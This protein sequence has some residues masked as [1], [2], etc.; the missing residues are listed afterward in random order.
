M[1]ESGI[2]LHKRSCIGRPDLGRLG[3]D[4]GKKSFPVS[5]GMARTVTHHLL[6]VALLHLLLLLFAPHCHNCSLSTSNVSRY[7]DS[8]AALLAWRSAEAIVGGSALWIGS[9]VK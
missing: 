2:T 3:A 6:V 1:G 7:I 8:V 9:L 4:A 5:C